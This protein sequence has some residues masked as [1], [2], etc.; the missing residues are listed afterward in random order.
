MTKIKNIKDAK[1]LA[2]SEGG[3]KSALELGAMFH[4]QVLEYHK[5][6]LNQIKQQICDEEEVSVKNRGTESSEKV[7]DSEKND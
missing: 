5:Y 3:Q 1:P 4:E 7:N 6:M 2:R